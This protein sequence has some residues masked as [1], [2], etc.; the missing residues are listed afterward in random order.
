M[1]PISDFRPRVAAFVHGC[2]DMLIDQAVLDACI[3]FCEQSLIIKQVL[4]AFYT[5]ANTPDYDLDAPPG[6]LVTLVHRAWVNAHELTPAAG[7]DINTPF[8]FSRVVGLN[9][10]ITAMPR[11]YHEFGP[12][13]LGLYPIPNDTYTITVQA[14]L[15][16]TRSATEVEDVLYQNWCEYIVAGALARLQM[17]P[18]EWGNPALATVNASRFMQGINRALL[19][20]SRQ[21]VRAEA[22]IK[23]V[24]I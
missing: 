10:D 13:V 21:L 19:E 17:Q 9:S 12:G 6:Q 14:A 20:A 8:A 24:H 3:E 23:P 16:P 5:Q 22:R 2:P 1:T 4:D 11:N 15:K 7:D 18:M